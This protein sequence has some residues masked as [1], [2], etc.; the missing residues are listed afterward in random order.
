[1]QEHRFTMKQLAQAI[2]ELGVEFLGFELTGKRLSMSFDEWEAYERAQ[3]DTFA[4]MYQF[5]IKR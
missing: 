1:V 2:A 4:S 3:P 5:W